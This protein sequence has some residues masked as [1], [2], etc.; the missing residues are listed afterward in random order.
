M[1]RAWCAIMGSKPKAP[2]KPPPPPPVPT[3]ADADAAANQRLDD[4]RR[5]RSSGASSFLAGETGASPSM[6]QAANG[7]T[8]L[9]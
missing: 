4:L 3:M 6:G 8:F 1:S 5:K 9:G 2:P 7:K